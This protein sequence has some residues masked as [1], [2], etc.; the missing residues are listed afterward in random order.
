MINQSKLRRTLL[1][2]CPHFKNK[3]TKILVDLLK[4]PFDLEHVS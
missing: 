2:V 1:E 3:Q 4:N